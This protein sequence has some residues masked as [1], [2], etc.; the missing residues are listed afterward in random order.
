MC[1]Y[2]AFNWPVMFCPVLLNL[3]S[4]FITLLY[5]STLFGQFLFGV[6]RKAPWRIGYCT[7]SASRWVLNSML[8]PGRWLAYMSMPFEVPF[9]VEDN[10]VSIESTVLNI[11]L[12]WAI[13]GSSAAKNQVTFS[14]RSSSS[15]LR[16]WK[17]LPVQSPRRCSVGIRAVI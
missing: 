12:W 1:I 11:I 13:W 2:L 14:L 8:F 6:Y 5:G 7:F 17:T 10:D 16:D 3:F 15:T 9:Q 4:S